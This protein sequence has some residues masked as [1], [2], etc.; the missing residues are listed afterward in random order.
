MKNANNVCLKVG[1]KSKSYNS[2]LILLKYAQ[3]FQIGFN[4]LILAIKVDN[5]FVMDLRF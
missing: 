4:N 2:N 5:K 1:I 3:H